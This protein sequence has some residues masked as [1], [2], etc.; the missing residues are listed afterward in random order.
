MDKYRRSAF[1]TLALNTAFAAYYFT[2]GLLWHSWW[3][4]TL[5]TYNLILSLV[6]FVV[7]CT[8]GREAFVAKFSGWMLM[9]LSI[10]LAGT[11]ILSVLRDRGQQLH[12]IIMIAIAAYAF[13][14]IALTT[15]NLI[16]SRRNS[17]VSLVA[18]RNISFADAVVSI[19]A[20]QRSM[21][22]S[23]EG[24]TE[25]EIMLMNG[26]TG[27]GTCVLVFLLGLSLVNKKKMPCK[28]PETNP[29]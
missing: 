22:V 28:A 14:R 18:L 6:R 7:L 11:V 13:T 25:A 19:F 5:G 24:M 16:K 4:L 23:F 15:I 27:T 8:K 20:L 2:Y 29:I 3:L 17:S 12:M 9:I 10:P 1:A 26:L 21:L